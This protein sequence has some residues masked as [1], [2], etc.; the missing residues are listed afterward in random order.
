LNESSNYQIGGIVFIGGGQSGKQMIEIADSLKSSSTPGFIFSEAI[1]LIT[2]FFRDH[3]KTI[4]S[5]KGSLVMSPVKMAVEDFKQYW[6]SLFTNTSK[7]Y[8]ESKTNPW[9]KELFFKFS[10]CT[11]NDTSCSPMSENEVRMHLPEDVFVSYGILAAYTMAKAVHQMHNKLCSGQNG[12]CDNL[13]I[14]PRG[15]YITELK[16][17]AVD[18]QTDFKKASLTTIIPSLQFDENGNAV[19][20]E[21]SPDYEVYNHRTCLSG[22]QRFCLVK[23]SLIIT[24]SYL[25]KD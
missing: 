4:N 19:F 11:E 23:V 3:N 22:E 14:V 25:S 1:G 16:E 9:L 13:E 21:S 24:E 6:I 5:S 20:T 8:E 7:L 17:I 12:L 10:R 15:Q 18:F 2:D